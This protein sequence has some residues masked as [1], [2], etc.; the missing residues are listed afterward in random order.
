MKKILF[1]LLICASFNLCAQT[2]NTTE[3]NFV[4]YGAYNIL[5]NKPMAG[6]T[7]GCDLSHFVFELEMGWSY[8]Y[9]ASTNHFYY[10]CP[11]V[12]VVW[13]DH[14]QIYALAGISQWAYMQKHPKDNDYS[15]YSDTWLPKLKL[16]ND[17]YI[18]KQTFVN[19]ELQ[20]NIPI[21]SSG[22]IP[23]QN[24]ALKTG[25]GFSF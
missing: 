22:M 13:G 20:Y 12:G 4:L 11:S 19:I 23:F 18:G 21:K 24:L 25:I 1:I 2:D 15:F 7:L 6:I 17:I 8:M 14:Y 3:N 16:G 10:V 5:E 9:Y